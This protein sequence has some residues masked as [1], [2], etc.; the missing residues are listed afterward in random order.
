[1]LAQTKIRRHGY[2]L[3][4]LASI[5]MVAVAVFGILT[6]AMPWMPDWHPQASG[7]NL[8]GLDWR[9]T[10]ALNQEGKTQL[11]LA[12][13]TWTL[14][15]LLPLVMLRRLGKRLYRHEALSRPVADA[16]LWLAHSLLLFAA[17]RFAGSLLVLSAVAAGSS[18]ATFGIN[19]S[20][21]YLFVILCLGMYSVAHI[22]R[23]AAE[24]AD[25]S[26]SIV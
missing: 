10:Q 16:F 14:A 8:A 12:G 11:S 25:D 20:D 21:A 6:S 7:W 9:Q 5:G 3:M 15:Y 19:F 4:S 13:L 2:H 18:T 26:R 23:L 22:M 24:A 17:L 1:M